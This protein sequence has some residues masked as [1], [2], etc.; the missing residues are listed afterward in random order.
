[1]ETVNFTIAGIT[2]DDLP[3]GQTLPTQFTVEADGSTDVT[4]NLREDA[5][6][7]GDETLTLTLDDVA[8]VSGSVTVVDSSQTPA[9]GGQTDVSADQGTPTVPAALD[10]GTDTFRFTDDADVAGSVVIS[11][12]ANGDTIAVSNAAATDYTFSNNGDDVTIT[13]NNNGTLNSIQLIDVVDAASDLVFNEA[14]FEQAIG[15]DAFLIV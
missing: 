15:F 7:E 12:F 5:T 8:N 1:G 3:A 2:A 6:T 9:A 13:Y 4:I 14:S 10:A 11:N